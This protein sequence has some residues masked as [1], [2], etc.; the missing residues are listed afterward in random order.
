MSWDYYDSD[1]TRT[2]ANGTLEG[3]VVLQSNG[4]RSKQKKELLCSYN[5]PVVYRM[6]WFESVPSIIQ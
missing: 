2:R 3:T 1:L 5:V 4:K 6:L